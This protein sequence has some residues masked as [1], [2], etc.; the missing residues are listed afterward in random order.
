MAWSGW[1][2]EWS[3]APDLSW[4]QLNRWAAYALVT[5]MQFVATGSSKLALVIG[6]DTNSRVMNPDDKKTFPLFGDGAGAVLLAK[7][8]KEQGL[9]SYTLGADGSGE[10]LL[11]RP[12]GGS[13]TVRWTR[14]AGAWGYVAPLRISGPAHSGRS[15]QGLSA[16]AAADGVTVDEART[17]P[18]IVNEVAWTLTVSDRDS[19]RRERYAREIMDHLMEANEAARQRPEYLDTWAATYA[20]TIKT[21]KKSEEV[22]IL[23]QNGNVKTFKVE[24]PRGDHARAWGSARCP[25]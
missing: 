13:L 3:I 19:L 6:A 12:A 2:V 23:L 20:A 25:R 15:S 17:D 1:S 4:V 5:G 22:R 9:I 18:N 16:V 21:R 24:P 7:G 8:S 10:Q 14:S 11:V